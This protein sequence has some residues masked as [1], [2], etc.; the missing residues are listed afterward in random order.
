MTSTNTTTSTA[1]AQPH[2]NPI[3]ANQKML[4]MSALGALSA[5]LNMVADHFKDDQRVYDFISRFQQGL[6]GFTSALM[7]DDY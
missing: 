2:V 7:S 1:P 6:T 4:L 5:G 3:P